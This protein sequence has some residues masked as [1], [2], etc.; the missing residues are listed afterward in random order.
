MMTIDLNCD[1]GEGM[2]NDSQIMP[3]ISSC[4]I[5]CGGHAGDA[6][7]IIES[8]KLARKYSVKI[9][10]HPSFEDPANFGRLRLEWSRSRFRE[11]MTHQLNLFTNVLSGVDMKLHHIKMHGA[12]Y[13]ATAHENSFAEWTVEWLQEFF[14]ETPIYSLPNSLLHQKCKAIQQPFI[15]EVFAD[16]AYLN[17]GA[18][19]S[20]TKAHAVHET[21]DE[22]LNQV[23]DIALHQKVRTSEG[24]NIDMFG[25]TFCIHGDNLK[26]VENLP[27]LI[28]QLNH[29][30]IQIAR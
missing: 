22:V 20:R 29:N 8:L 17:N 19:V 14:P 21:I 23:L 6:A 3:H 12:L 16:R 24:T 1:L 25:D 26:L 10:A 2:G 15:K 7:S 5:A 28:K 11:S 9:G 27:K 30:N 4:N 13:H 18:L